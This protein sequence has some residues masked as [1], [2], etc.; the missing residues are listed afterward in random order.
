MSIE[1]QGRDT[2]PLNTH[3]DWQAVPKAASATRA[4]DKSANRNKTY[5][6]VVHITVV[7]AAKKHPEVCATV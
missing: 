7:D 2:T 6:K 5:L 3:V 1:L 4:A